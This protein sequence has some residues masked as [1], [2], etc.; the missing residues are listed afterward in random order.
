VLLC[1]NLFLESTVDIMSELPAALLLLVG[2]LSL[3]R[4]RFWWSAT[5]FALVVFTRWNL[6]PVWVV[7]FVAVLIRFGLRQALKFLGVGLTI[8]SAW[9]VVTIAMGTPD[10][11]HRVYVD[12]FLPGLTWAATPGQKP[13]FLLRVDFYAKHFFFLTPPVFFALIANPVHN[14]GKHLRTE[15]WIILIVLPLAL[16]VYIVTMLNIGALF[17]RFIT[18]LIPSAVV[19]LLLG[20]SKFCD[21]FS[22]PELSR[23]RI[24]TI[25]L[26]LACAVGLWPLSAVVQARVNLNTPSVFSTNLRKK[27]IA[28]DRDVLLYGVPREPLSRANGHPAMVEARHSILFPA[29]RRDFTSY[30]IEEPDSIETVHKLAAGCHPGDLLLIPKKYASDFQP[31][32]VLFSDGQWSLVRNP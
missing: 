1:Q 23:I 5:C 32:A 15:F 6:A 2:F 8:F 17:P 29:A 18:P 19:S 14:L 24:V 11:L 12:N 25:A 30:I 4:E 7:V 28:L 27:L 9:Y 10:P 13:D 20:L 22:F 16:L 21:D 26:F 31:A 3:A